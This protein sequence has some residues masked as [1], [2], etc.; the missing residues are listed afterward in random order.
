M[1]AN[2]ARKR[3]LLVG[4]L[5]GLICLAGCRHNQ[6]AAEPSSVERQPA[7][8]SGGPPEGNF[9]DI[10]GIERT[11]GIVFVSGWAASPEWGAPVEKIEITLDD[12]VV[13]LAN[14]LNVARPDLVAARHRS[15]WY[16]GGWFGEVRLTGVSSGLH[17]LAAVVYDSSGA[18]TVLPS[19]R[20]F[21]VNR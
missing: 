14:P 1:G 18:K 16:G 10:M 12:Q 4:G 3:A 20:Q 15:D 7:T 21:L 5:L 6:G 11:D 2:R 19:H 8:S 9:E 17:K 13:A